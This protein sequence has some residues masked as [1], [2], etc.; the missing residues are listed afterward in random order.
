MT[1]DS[2]NTIQ[3]DKNERLPLMAKA[4]QLIAGASS[5]TNWPVS[6]EF[7]KENLLTVLKDMDNSQIQR[8][9]DILETEKRKIQE[10]EKNY[11]DSLAATN[12]RHIQEMSDSY[13]SKNNVSNQKND[14]I[15]NKIQKKWILSKFFWFWNKK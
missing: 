8:L 6:D 3:E 1:K 9:I 2:N 5:L 7:S 12:K 11:D 13:Y 4:K 14:T 15:N 10:L